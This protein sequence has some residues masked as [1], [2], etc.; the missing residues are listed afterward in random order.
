MQ[1]K[2]RRWVAA[3]LIVA[4]AVLLFAAPETVGGL[5]AIG[6]G[7]LVELI[8]IALEKRR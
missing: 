3:L 5:I 6:A 2:P 4:G 7:V 1:M 8:G